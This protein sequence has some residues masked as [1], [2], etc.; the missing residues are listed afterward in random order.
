MNLRPV[1]NLEPH[2]GLDQKITHPFFYFP[3]GDSALCPNYDEQ[4]LK[5]PLFLSGTD[6]N[7][8]ML[9]VL[10]AIEALR[11]LPSKM[12]SVVRSLIKGF[13]CDD[14]RVLS[15]CLSPEDIKSATEKYSAS[16]SPCSNSPRL[17]VS[18]YKSS[19]IDLFSA[20]LFSYFLLN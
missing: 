8:F 5:Q 7:F 11:L 14:V 18:T 2:T 10:L 15:C 12:D 3:Y 20:L 16:K 4:Q 6:L 19:V 17:S 9:D 13:I 1:M